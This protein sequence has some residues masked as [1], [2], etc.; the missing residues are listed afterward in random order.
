MPLLLYFV[1]ML[2]V[3]DLLIIGFILSVWGS[4]Q[5]HRAQKHMMCPAIGNPT[6]CEIRAV[7]HFLHTK[8]MSAVAI[9]CE[10]CMF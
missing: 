8:N 4:E 2:Q 10:L 3:Y 7:I 1:Y 9:H 6:S 5:L